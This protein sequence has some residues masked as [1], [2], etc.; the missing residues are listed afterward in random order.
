MAKETR[1]MHESVTTHVRG[2]MS[3][4]RMC[5]IWGKYPS[6]GLVHPQKVQK[7]NAGPDCPRSP[8]PRTLPLGKWAQPAS[9]GSGIPSSSLDPSGVEI[10]DRR[11][12]SIS[13]G[14]L[15]E[16]KIR[17]DRGETERQ[18]LA[19]DFSDGVQLRANSIVIGGCYGLQVS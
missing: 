5:E 7:V 10:G 6:E 11:L 18:F 13:L 14:Q 17:T 1:E 19:V 16:G 3:A 2:S 9:R 12:Q 4:G 8:L 15:I